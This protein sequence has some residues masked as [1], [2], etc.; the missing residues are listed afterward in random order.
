MRFFAIPTHF[1]GIRARKT[2]LDGG[3]LRGASLVA[4]KRTAYSKIIIAAHRQFLI[5]RSRIGVVGAIFQNGRPLVAVVRYQAVVAIH[6]ASQSRIKVERA[7][8]E[9][10][11]VNV[12]GLCNCREHHEAQCKK[13]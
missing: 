8:V 2:G 5:V 6:H 3:K 10:R 12:L 9:L 7:L 4:P 1:F 11:K 13:V